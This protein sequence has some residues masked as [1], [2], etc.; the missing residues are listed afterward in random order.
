MSTGDTIPLLRLAYCS[1]S[2]MDT[3]RGSRLHR[4]QCRLLRD[5]CTSLRTRER[6]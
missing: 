5:A 3:A 6:P 2:S 1:K 4:G